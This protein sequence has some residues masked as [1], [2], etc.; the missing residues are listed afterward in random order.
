MSPTLEPSTGIDDLDRA[1]HGLLWGDNVV[2]ETDRAETAAPFFAAISEHAPTYDWAAYVS[3]R[4]PPEEVR[5]RFPELAYVDARPDAE[6]AEPGPLLNAIRRQC[7]P[8]GRNLLLFD[9]L[10]DMTERWGV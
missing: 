5:T 8:R 2:F 7:A 9:P 10:E 6:L 1:M 3:L 4:H